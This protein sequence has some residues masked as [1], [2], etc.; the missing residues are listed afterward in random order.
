[1]EAVWPLYTMTLLPVLRAGRGTGDVA[2]PRDHEALLLA[3]HLV[4]EPGDAHRR[5]EVAARSEGV[6]ARIDDADRL[7]RLRDGERVE[8]LLPPELQEL[9]RAAAD[10]VGRDLDRQLLLEH[11]RPLLGPDALQRA[12]GGGV[13]RGRIL[14]GSERGADRLLDVVLELSILRL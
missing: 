14:A 8:G 11:G 6:V 3:A 7:L 13:L 1:M 10:V 2:R 5:A 12:H 9:A 4:A